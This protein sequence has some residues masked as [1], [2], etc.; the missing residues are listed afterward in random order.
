MTQDLLEAELAKARAVHIE[1]KKR[2]KVQPKRL[3]FVDQAH[4]WVDKETG[5]GG[6]SNDQEKYCL[7]LR[8]GVP[9]SLKRLR[10]MYYIVIVL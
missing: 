5:N 8:H 3:V 7:L 1:V 10:R 2:G 4:R 9:S 6:H